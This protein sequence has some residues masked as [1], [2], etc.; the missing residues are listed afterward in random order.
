[1]ILDAN[2]HPIFI[3]MPGSGKSTLGRAVAKRLGRAFIDTDERMESTTGLSLQTYMD[4]H[5]PAAFARL[6]SATGLGLSPSEPTLVATGGSM[7]YSDEAMAHLA[8]LGPVVFLDVPLEILQ[9]RVGCGSD[10]GLLQRQS[11]GLSALW[12]E[13]RPL[14]LRHADLIVPLEEGDP[15]AQAEHIA[16]LLSTRE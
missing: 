11:G 13:R 9:A 14:Y 7:I 3:G 1:M 10:R 12:E 15:N 4:T 16:R 6:E 2:S 5:G 8:R